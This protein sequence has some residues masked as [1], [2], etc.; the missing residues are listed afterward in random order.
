VRSE[1]YEEGGVQVAVSI[2]GDHRPAPRGRFYGVRG[3]G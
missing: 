3:M 1:E 2:D